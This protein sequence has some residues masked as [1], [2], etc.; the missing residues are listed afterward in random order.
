MN[1]TELPS[2]SE[3]VGVSL[4][5]DHVAIVEMRRPPHNF[6]DMGMLVGLADAFEQL[7]NND[8]CRS[9]VLCA[10]GTSFCAGADFSGKRDPA[11]SPRTVNPIYAE[12]IRLFA[13]T[14][15]SV[16]AVQGPAIGGGMGLSLVTDFRVTC[17]EARFSANF[18]RLGFHP[19]FGLTAT[20][21]RLIG[22]QKAA[23]MFYTGRRINGEEAAAMGLAEVLTTREKVR[24]EAIA[25][26]REM[27]ISAPLAVVSTRATVR[28]GL[29]EQVRSA[30]A[31]ESHEQTLHYMT[32]DF[33][34]GVAA[35]AARREPQFQGR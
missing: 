23:L 1:M 6:F 30:V 10:A 20:L 26:A 17:P 24:D 8:Q 4:R 2:S 7:E 21:P 16:G 19:G 18:N 35:M 25:L 22:T 32:E 9:I 5:D 34:E 12:A 14:K 29:V 15:P 31:R 27:A 28:A 3:F 33:K 11:R 13:C